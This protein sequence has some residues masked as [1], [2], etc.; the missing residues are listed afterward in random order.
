MSLIKKLVGDT[1]IYGLSFILGRILNYVVLGF[2]LTFKVGRLEYGIYNEFYFYVAFLL[3][4]LTFR[5]ETTYFRYSSK[6]GRQ[7]V[8]S[9]AVWNIAINVLLFWFLAMLYSESIAQALSYPGKGYYIRVLASVVAL[10]ALVAVPFARLRMENHAMRFAFIKI[11]QILVNV[12]L[13][14][15]F[16]EGMPH[17]MRLGIPYIHILYHP[18]DI[19]L[20]VFIANLLSSIFA[21]IMLSKQFFNLRLPDKKLWYKMIRYA[22]PLVLIGLAGV[23][24]QYSYTVFQKYKLL[25]NILDNVSNVGI[26]SAALKIAMLL[27]LFTT[28]FNYA[29]EPFFFQNASRKDSPD[30]Y[31]DVARIYS[32]TAGI[33]ILGVLQYIDLIQYLVGKD[34]RVGLSL[35]PVLLTAFFFLGLYYNFSIWYKLKDRTTTGAWIALT[36][37]LV[38]LVLS[39]FLIP[40]IGKVGSAWAALGCY[41][42][43]AFLA[44]VI[45]RK[46]YPIP[47]KLTRMI[48][49]LIITLG[50]YFLSQYS[51]TF[52][53]KNI[54]LTWTIKTIWFAAYLI[55]IYFI[56]AKWIK[57]ALHRT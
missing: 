6:E 28:A 10:D 55:S 35:A 38:T 48:L 44:W 26:Y 22:S 9:V 43:M 33:I 57:K 51:V 41:L 14:L 31:A 34:F 2:Y 17:F 13:V 5:M 56:E 37:T 52:F 32:L 53:H 27:S 4:L 49:W 47:Y 19:I 18:K 42:T 3:I 39:L 8:F 7:K 15:F 30:L 40:K 36:G 16:I 12:G 46:Y 24:N 50:V 23:F 11:L 20:D 45:G 25:G 29:A 1:A 54:A 21:W